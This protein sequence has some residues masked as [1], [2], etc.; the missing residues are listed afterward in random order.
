MQ[1]RFGHS[2][3]AILDSSIARLSHSLAGRRRQS[4][5]AHAHNLPA[6]PI[7]DQNSGPNKLRLNL[8]EFTFQVY[9][10]RR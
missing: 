7:L 6:T 8:D 5:R 4:E 1:A 3:T 10:G 9:S 2:R